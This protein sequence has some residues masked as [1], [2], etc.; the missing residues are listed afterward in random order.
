MAKFEAR[1]LNWSDP[2]SSNITPYY[3]Y[4]LESPLLSD[5]FF[6]QPFVFWWLKCPHMPVL[7]HTCILYEFILLY[8]ASPYTFCWTSPLFF[9]PLPSHHPDVPSAPQASRANN[10]FFYFL[11][12]YIITKYTWMDVNDNYIEIN[13]VFLHFVFL[14]WQWSLE[15]SPDSKI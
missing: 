1:S 6:K 13:T 14:I 11:H 8:Y 12:A 9:P 10:T 4:D 15:I 2:Q 3:Y 7:A 5:N